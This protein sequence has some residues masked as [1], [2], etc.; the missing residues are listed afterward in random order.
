MQILRHSKIAVTMEVYA[1][2]VSASTKDA[3]RRLGEQLDSGDAACS[4]LYFA[5]AGPAVGFECGLS[6]DQ[7]RD[8]QDESRSERR[9]SYSVTHRPR[10]PDAQGWHG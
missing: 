8:G 9:R 2:V 1:E 7:D 3:L 10:V 4:L 6:V 5:A